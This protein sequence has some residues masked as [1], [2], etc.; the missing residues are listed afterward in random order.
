MAKGRPQRVRSRKEADAYWTQPEA[1]IKFVRRD[2]TPD[3]VVE[4]RRRIKAGESVDDVVEYF[5]NLI[6]GKA[7]E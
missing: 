5:Y 7:K 3:Q 1:G 2:L 4:G 6:T